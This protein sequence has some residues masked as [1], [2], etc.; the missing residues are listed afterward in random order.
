MLTTLQLH[1][2]ICVK[3]LSQTFQIVTKSIW[4]FKFSYLLNYFDIWLGPNEPDIK[5][6]KLNR[7]DKTVKKG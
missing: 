4:I 1:S 6:S 2:Y 5:I 7:K 3:T